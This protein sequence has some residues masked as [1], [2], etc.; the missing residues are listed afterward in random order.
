MADPNYR[1][2][3]APY[4]A[5]IVE[6]AEV[7]GVD[8]E[9]LLRGAGIT[10]ADLG[11]PDRRLPADTVLGLWRR[12]VALSGDPDFGLHVGERLR[13]PLLRVLGQA[14]ANCRTL[15]EAAEL[16]VGYQ[17]LLNDVSTISLDRR[18]ARAVLSFHPAAAEQEPQRAEA[19]FAAI[20]TVGRWI[21]RADLSPAAVRFRRDAPTTGTGEYRRIFRCPITFGAVDDEIELA[22]EQLAEP[23][24]FADPA[25]LDLHREYADRLVSDLP[26]AGA[27]TEYVRRR[28]REDV[29][30][31]DQRAVAESLHLSLR[32]LQRALS[33]EG[34][35]WQAL[36]DEIRHTRATQLLA[37]RGPGG[38]AGSR[39][40]TL[41]EVAAA[42]GYS[43]PS[44]FVRAFKRWEGTTPGAYAARSAR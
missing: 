38:A 27:L 29:A 37:G 11:A 13:P 28:I 23:I 5:A 14:V 30:G 21:T 36:L 44:A 18:G 39:A 19:V 35:S 17:R 43:E 31:A 6:A 8:R 3:V 12:A 20:L 1:T 25:L 22:A 9:K 41:A 7:G 10:E 33:S 15:G 32:S 40:P 4:A 2:M 42:L 26:A 24:P 34:T 16:L